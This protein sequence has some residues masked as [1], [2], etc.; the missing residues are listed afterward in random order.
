MTTCT[1]P[2]VQ[3][4]MCKFSIQLPQGGCKHFPPFDQQ[5]HHHICH[6]DDDAEADVNADDGADADDDEYNDDCAD[7]GDD[8]D[9]GSKI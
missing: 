9:A 8:E 7:D 1:P 4:C 5:H 6:D 2:T 3:S